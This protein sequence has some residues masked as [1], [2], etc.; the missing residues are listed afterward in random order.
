MARDTRT[1]LLRGF[2]A[3][4]GT[5]ALWPVVADAVLVAPHALFLGDRN[6]SGQVYLVNQGSAAEEVTLELQ[7]GFPVS[8]STGGMR[9]E[10]IPNPG[11]EYP[12]A[13]AWLR[14][15]PRRARVEPGQRQAVRIQASPPAN[16]PDGE[17]WS[18]L[19]VTSHEVTPPTPVSGDTGVRAGITF[20]LRTI[21]SVTYRKGAVR[22]GVRLDSL[23]ASAVADTIAVWLGLSREGNAAFLGSARFE[24]VDPA[25]RAVRQWPATPIA[26]YYKVLRRF[27][28]PLD[29]LPPGRYRLRLLVSTERQDIAFQSV[30]PA[31]PVERIVEVDVP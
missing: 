30:L 2:G 23:S 3:A 6:R 12:S 26:V 14:A 10:L 5:L 4:L 28:L 16:L 21:T 27:A 7:F 18:R 20:E 17:Y 24:V 31:T 22:T 25:G 1:H 8:D 9:I 13:A 15:F 11:P 19:I 29:S